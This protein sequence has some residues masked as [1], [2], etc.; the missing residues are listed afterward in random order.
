MI[1]HYIVRGIIMVE[2]QVLLAHQIGADNTFFPGGH[3]EVGE[4]ARAALVREIEE[5]FGHRVTVGR[6]VGAVEHTWTEDGRHNHEL[7]L[8]FAVEVAG[9]HPPVS[10]P[11]H[12]S[13]LEFIWSA[14]EDLAAHNLQPHTLIPCLTHWDAEYRAYWASSLEG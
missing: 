12:E 13:H 3:V 7:N 8:I 5:E 10:P 1:F 11:S 2:G 4:S 9:L 14:P 6:F